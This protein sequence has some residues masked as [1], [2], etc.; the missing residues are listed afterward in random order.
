MFRDSVYELYS[1]TVDILPGTN[2]IQKF[3][4]DAQHMARAETQSQLLRRLFSCSQLSN[5]IF[6]LTKREID[7]LKNGRNCSSRG[8]LRVTHQVYGEGSALETL[9][10]YLYLSDR[11]RLQVVLDKLNSLRNIQDPSLDHKII[12]N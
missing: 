4:D 9:I 12:W 10:G 3:H 1:R 6:E 11:F 2:R 5:D 7:I 8:P